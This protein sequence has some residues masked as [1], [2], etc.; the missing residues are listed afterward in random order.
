[1]VSDD[2]SAHA[3]ASKKSSSSFDSGPT[4]ELAALRELMETTLQPLADG[5]IYALL[6]YPD[7]F[8]PGDCAIWLGECRVLK[9][10][11][12]R[13]PSLV[14]SLRSF[15]PRQLRRLPEA[16]PIFLQGGG[17][18]GDLWPAHQNFREQLLAQADN[19]RIVLLTQSIQFRTMVGLEKA[20]RAFANHKNVTLLVRDASSLEF[21]RHHF[22]CASQLCPDFALALDLTRPSSGM[23]CDVLWLLR[24]DKESSGVSIASMRPDWARADWPHPRLLRRA[25]LHR[26]SFVP[27]RPYALIA[28]M[29]AGARMM[30][31]LRLVSRAHAVVT[32]RLHGHVLSTL[33]GIPNVLLP[34]AF[35]K[36]R[37]LY[38]SWTHS[39]PGCAFAETPDQA[40]SELERLRRSYVVTGR[41]H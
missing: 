34:D 3:F 28:G 18:F 21:A 1:M 9:K 2:I 39:L 40:L 41:Q 10:L 24:Q 36:N 19:R 23:C 5:P 11:T 25:W 8:N 20:K 16:A 14:A 13:T 6:D 7:Y 27:G 29:L 32:D 30:A 35:G 22:E 12:G 26:A 38:E 4:S 15:D 17:N 33:L 31:G 37:G